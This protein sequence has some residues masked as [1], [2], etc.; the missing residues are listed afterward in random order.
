MRGCVSTVPPAGRE[1]LRKYRLS[2]LEKWGRA[3]I[4]AETLADESASVRLLADQAIKAFEVSTYAARDYA[5]AVFWRL[6]NEEG[7]PP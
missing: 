1:A 3:N 2:E 6:S 7:S 4:P 5:K